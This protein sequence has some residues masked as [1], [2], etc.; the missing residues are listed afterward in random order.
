MAGLDCW[1]MQW[2]RLGVGVEVEVFRLSLS[3]RLKMTTSATGQRTTLAMG[4]DDAWRWAEDNV[5]EGIYRRGSVD[6]FGDCRSKDS[7]I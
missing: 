4:E 6:D 1:A 3:D 5:G 7:P 2:W